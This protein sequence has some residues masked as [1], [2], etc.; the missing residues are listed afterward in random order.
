MRHMESTHEPQ[1]S[2]R[3][4]DIVHVYAYK[5]KYKY[6]V[7]G[8]FGKRFVSFLLIKMYMCVCICVSMFGFICTI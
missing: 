1:V 3:S 7:Y 2:I 6:I 4:K 5:Y 8:T